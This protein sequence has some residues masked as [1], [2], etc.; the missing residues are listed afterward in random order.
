MNI[1]I[2]LLWQMGF[3]LVFVWFC[4]TYV[5]S[6]I[7]GAINERKTTIAD[8]L[9][10]A[11]KGQQAE[12]EGLERAGQ[13]V[14][15]AKTQAGDIISRAEKHGSELIAQ[16]REQ[17][18]AE[19]ERILAAAREEIATETNR[20]KEMLRDRVS[21]LAVAG[22][23]QILQREVDEKTHADLLNQLAAKL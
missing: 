20:A 8:G 2:T 21:E 9:A 7:L 19:G 13:H 17:A 4:K 10:A 5:W 14:A 18:H 6:P 22:A 23:R 15:E 3:F 16:A 12:A 1:N 11:A